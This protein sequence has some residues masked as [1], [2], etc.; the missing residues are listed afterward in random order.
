MYST[1][2]K[3]REREFEAACR[4]L[5]GV[6]DTETFQH[7]VK[8]IFD[9]VAT[10]LSVD[11]LSNHPQLATEPL[12]EFDVKIRLHSGRLASRRFEATVVGVFL[13]KGLLG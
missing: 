7:E 9:T 8:R 13:R 2:F 11:V 5:E 1:S 4:S 3:K 10:S 6:A 12:D